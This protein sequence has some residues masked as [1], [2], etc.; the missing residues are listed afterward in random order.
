MDVATAVLCVLRIPPLGLGR[1]GQSAPAGQGL[2]SSAYEY[3]LRSAVQ[4]RELA[5]WCVCVR[6]GV[7]VH[8]CVTWHLMVKVF[9]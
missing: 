2:P 5:E 6:V 4:V 8:V 3:A 7:G 1:P 9:R